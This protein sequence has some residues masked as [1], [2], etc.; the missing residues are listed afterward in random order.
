[1][2][3]A[4]NR[5]PRYSVVTRF[6]AFSPEVAHSLGLHSTLTGGVIACV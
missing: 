2:G 1:M 5:Q 4:A 6:T 3:I